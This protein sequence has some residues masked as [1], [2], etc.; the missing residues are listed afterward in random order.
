M[1]DISLDFS[2]V[3]GVLTLAIIDFGLLLAAA[4]L[5]I[6]AL[7]ARFKPGGNADK[8]HWSAERRF[9]RALGAAVSATVSAAVTIGIGWMVNEKIFSEETRLHLDAL[10]WTWIFAAILLWRIT[11][12]LAVLANQPQGPA[13]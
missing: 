3:V 7:D 13:L 10:A 11:M 5:L 2:G 9:Q 4:V 6:L 1:S 8:L 12:R